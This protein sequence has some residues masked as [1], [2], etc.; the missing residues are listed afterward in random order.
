MSTK[1]YIL[2]I[3]NNSVPFLRFKDSFFLD[4]P[5][6]ERAREVL[7][8]L[9]EEELVAESVCFIHK[10]LL[11]NCTIANKKLK[12]ENSGNSCHNTKFCSTPKIC[13]LA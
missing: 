9:V 8:R 13:A 10:L 11:A 12:K 2:F 7:Q 5:S 3:K 1:F 6:G 4:G